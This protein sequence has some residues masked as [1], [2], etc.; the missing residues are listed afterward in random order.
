MQALAVE[1]Q[2]KKVFFDVSN[3][4][5]VAKVDFPLVVV[6]HTGE[7]ILGV[8]NFRGKV[9]PVYNLNNALGYPADYRYRYLLVLEKESILVGILSDKMPKIQEAET[10]ELFSIDRLFA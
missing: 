7:N 1:I 3:A 9:L 4:H 8:I 10:A 6:P 2:D 5:A